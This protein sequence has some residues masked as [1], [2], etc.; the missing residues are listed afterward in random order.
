[1]RAPVRAH[2]FVDRLLKTPA[3]VP[4]R[5]VALAQTFLHPGIVK[6]LNKIHATLII[7][8]IINCFLQ[9]VKM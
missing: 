8:I 3:P 9:L 6:S 1:M 2:P 5:N 7:I 4:L